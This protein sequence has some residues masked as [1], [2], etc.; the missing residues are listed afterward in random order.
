MGRSE[1]L[2]TKSISTEGCSGLSDGLSV[3]W[4]M[5]MMVLLFQANAREKERKGRKGDFMFN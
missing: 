3:A 1:F 2:M 5:E 4:Q